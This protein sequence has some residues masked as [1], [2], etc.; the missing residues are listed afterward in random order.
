M[1]QA[2]Y[3]FGVNFRALVFEVN[4]EIRLLGNQDLVRMDFLVGTAAHSKLENISAESS[5]GNCGHRFSDCANSDLQDALRFR[6]VVIGSVSSGS[7]PCDSSPHV[8]L[9]RIAVDP[10][11]PFR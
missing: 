8:G 3:G 6:G 7:L 2:S 11:F 4:W 5:G 10:G 9:D 1:A